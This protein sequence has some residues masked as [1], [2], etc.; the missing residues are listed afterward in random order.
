MTQTPNQVR[1]E[2]EKF[3][4]D[5]KIGLTHHFMNQD[6]DELVA[7][8]L[9]KV[10]EARR[11]ALEEALGVIPKIKECIFEETGCKGYSSTW[12]CSQHNAVADALSALATKL[13]ALIEQER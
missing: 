6:D 10:A 5:Y 9:T 8:L 4:K 12:C 3:M 2:F 13:S 7:H 1:E 11:G